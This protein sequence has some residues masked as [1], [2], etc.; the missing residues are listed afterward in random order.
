MATHNFPLHHHSFSN[1]QIKLSNSIKLCFAPSS[2]RLIML[3]MVEKKQKGERM[4]LKLNDDTRVGE[5]VW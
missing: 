5:S 4:S 1:V 2:I 3:T